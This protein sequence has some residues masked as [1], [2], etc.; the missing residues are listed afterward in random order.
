MEKRKLGTSDLL[1]SPLTFGGNVFGWTL[2]GAASFKILDA[3][4]E[5]G[6][7]LIDTAD[8]YS[9]FVPGNNGGESETIIGNWLKKEAIEKI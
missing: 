4:A 7:N 2:D 3:F 9:R 5:A 8:S 6:F 1:V